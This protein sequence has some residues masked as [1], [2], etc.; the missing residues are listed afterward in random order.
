[1]TIYKVS[2]YKLSIYKPVPPMTARTHPV[3][4]GGGRETDAWSEKGGTGHEPLTLVCSLDKSKA[5]WL[6]VL[7]SGPSLQFKAVELSPKFSLSQ[8][9]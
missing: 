3:S 1:M 4:R 5:V 7:G 8:S 6:R 2:T 9:A